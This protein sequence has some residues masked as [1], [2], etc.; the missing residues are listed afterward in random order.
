MQGSSK[1]KKRAVSLFSSSGVEQKLA[2]R[3]SKL[4]EVPEPTPS[5]PVGSQTKTS[6][7]LDAGFLIGTVSGTGSGPF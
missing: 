7:P 2:P 1:N 3:I 6:T 5:D 4:L